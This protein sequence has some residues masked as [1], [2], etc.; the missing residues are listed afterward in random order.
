MFNDTPSSLTPETL[1]FPR[2]YIALKGGGRQRSF[3]PSEVAEI[4]DMYDRLVPITE[5][6]TRTGSDKR[7]LR[8][9]FPWLHRR[10]EQRRRNVYRRLFDDGCSIDEI[11]S[12]YNVSINAVRNGLAHSGAKFKTNRGLPIEPTEA[13]LAYVA[14]IIDGEGCIRIK[15]RRGWRE[16]SPRYDLEITVTNTEKALLLW[17]QENLGCGSIYDKDRSAAR[18]PHWNPTFA[19]RVTEL[20]AADLLRRIHPYLVIKK[21]QCETAL[22]FQ[23]FRT[24]NAG[25]FKTPSTRWA[26]YERLRIKVRMLKLRNHALPT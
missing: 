8:R 22:E 10:A 9:Q 25:R 19:W 18:K 3:T 2:R 26:V 23:T 4:R 14:G 12:V 21:S 7:T 20:K 6:A 5:I 13:T 11:A 1:F 15:R 17:L 24:S 16:G